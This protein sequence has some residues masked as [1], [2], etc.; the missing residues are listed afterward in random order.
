MTGSPR[1]AGPETA[2]REAPPDRADEDEIHDLMIVRPP[3]RTCVRH[4]CGPTPDERPGGVRSRDEPLTGPS[5]SDDVVAAE[6][7]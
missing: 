5:P 6:R 1:L 3:G 2:S 4:R 7:V